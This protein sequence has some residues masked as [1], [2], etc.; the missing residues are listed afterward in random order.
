MMCNFLIKTKK[1]YYSGK[2]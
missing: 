2:W 1:E